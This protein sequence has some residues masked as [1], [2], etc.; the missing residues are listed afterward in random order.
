MVKGAVLIHLELQLHVFLA[1]LCA[2]DCLNVVMD[3]TK[4]TAQVHSKCYT[5]ILNTTSFFWPID[6]CVQAGME[7]FN[8]PAEQLCVPFNYLCDGVP[9]CG[10]L[11]T[12]VDENLPDCIG[13]YYC[14][15]TVDYSSYHRYVPHISVKYICRAGP[16]AA[17]LILTARLT[18]TLQLSKDLKFEIFCFDSIMLD[19]IQ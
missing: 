4:S 5:L 13:Q 11:A 3:L 1:Y 6:Y 10:A 18:C 17:S 14:V 8:C 12:A 2:T 9:D 19:Y 16:I 7:G 15:S